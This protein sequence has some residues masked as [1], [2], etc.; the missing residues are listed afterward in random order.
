[1]IGET[2]DGPKPGGAR[3]SC[4]GVIRHGADRP[5][6]DGLRTAEGFANAIRDADAD[7]FPGAAGTGSRSRSAVN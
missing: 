4:P 2:P 6:P 3:G 1:M 7:S 5:A